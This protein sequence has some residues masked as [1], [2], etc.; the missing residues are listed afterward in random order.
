MCYLASFLNGVT[1][2]INRNS[3]RALSS[4]MTKPITDHRSE[5]ISSLPPIIDFRTSIFNEDK[6]VHK[7]FMCQRRIF[8]CSK[9]TCLQRSFSLIH[10]YKSSN[11]TWVP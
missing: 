10:P 4:L 5:E 1:L 11:L 9:I 6:I 3:S 2:I 8:P 7:I